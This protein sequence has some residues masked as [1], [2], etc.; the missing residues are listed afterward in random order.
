MGNYIVL[1]DREKFGDLDRCVI[2]WPTDAQEERHAEGISRWD[3]G[4]LID[5]TEVE[6]V[7]L[8]LDFLR[9]VLSSHPPQPGARS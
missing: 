9:R 7:E 1:L 2:L 6:R 4:G 5:D 3:L 8:S